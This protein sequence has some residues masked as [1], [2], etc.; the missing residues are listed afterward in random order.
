MALLA[1]IVVL[2]GAPLQRSRVE[3]SVDR[4]SLIEQKDMSKIIRTLIL[5]RSVKFIIKLISLENIN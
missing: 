3:L 5:I 4:E 2:V 1:A